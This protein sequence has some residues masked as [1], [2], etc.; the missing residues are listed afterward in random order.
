M[1]VW[2]SWDRLLLSLCGP[3]FGLTQQGSC[4]SILSA[5]VF[6]VSVL[7]PCGPHSSGL[8]VGEFIYYSLYEGNAMKAK[9]YRNAISNI[10]SYQEFVH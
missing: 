2:L 10:K 3:T 8:I 5:C 1:F 9:N 4:S 6:A 7:C